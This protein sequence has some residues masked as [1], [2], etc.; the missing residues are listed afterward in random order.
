MKLLPLLLP[1][2]FALPTASRAAPAGSDLEAFVAKGIAEFHGRRLERLESLK[3]E[4]VL[5]RKNPYLLKAKNLTNA[6][7]VVAHLLNDHLGIQESSLFGFFLEQLAI[8]VCA[9]AYGGRKSAVEGIDLEFEKDG[10]KYIVSI[11]S[12]PNWG[13]SSS[14]AKMED[15]FRKAKR[16]LGTNTASGAKVVAVNGC[17]Y[18]RVATEDKGHY[19]KLCGQNFWALVS[20][21]DS[22]YLKIIDLIGDGPA[23]HDTGFEEGYQKTLARFAATF[24]ENYCDADGAVLWRKLA[25]MNSGTAP[26]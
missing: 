2:F 3:L 11:K 12:G 19:L 20:G 22:L 8:H 25:E 15:H 18:G 13:N 1:L 23:L 7:A 14:I 9:K 17:C 26:K 21:D 5:A 10:I 4:T 24:A 16:I 6:E